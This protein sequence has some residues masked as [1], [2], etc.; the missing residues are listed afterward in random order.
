MLRR[1][2]DEA[3]TYADPRGTLTLAARRLSII[4]VEHGHQPCSNEDGTVWAVQNGEIYNFERL[5]ERLQAEG[6]RLSSRCDTEVLVHLYERYGRELVHAIE[7][8]FAFAIW[9]EPRQRLLLGRDRC[10]EKPLFVRAEHGGIAFASELHALMEAGAAEHIEL[11]PRSLDAYFVLGYVPPDAALVEGVFQLA[12]GS[13]L[14]WSP[15]EPPVVSSYWSPPAALGPPDSRKL[16]ELV[17]ET[18]E[19]LAD[20]VASRMVSDVPLGLFLSGGMD[21]TL[22]AAIARERGGVRTFSVGYDVGDV[23]ETP[24]AGAVAQRLGLQHEAVVLR[25][26]DVEQ[27][28]LGVLAAIDQ[29]L[30][31]QALLPTFELARHA[32]RAVKVIVGGEGADEFFA[33]YPRYRWL[34]RA[35]RFRMPAARRALGL[36]AHAWPGRPAR[37]ERLALLAADLPE[38]ARNVRWVSAGRLDVRHRLYGERL[39]GV[40]DRTPVPARSA[41]GEPNG[42]PGHRAMRRDQR[43]WLA[44]DVL[45]KADRAGM[46]NSLEIRTPYLNRE[47]IEFA[48]SVSFETHAHDGGKALL[49]RVLKRRMPGHDAPRKRGFAVPAAEWLRGPLRNYVEHCANDSRLVRDGWFDAGALEAIAREHLSGAADN[50]ATLWPLVALAAWLEGPHGARVG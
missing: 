48:C 10:G 47:L 23:S 9:D 16:D 13:I 1:G 50:A 43:T 46:L 31:D 7:G 21:S 41:A 27:L 24:A 20:A 34:E 15:G 32:R 33:G 12:P 40:L 14:E 22:V 17:A 25:S 39:R 11:D 26:D 35:A 4:D 6:H 2:P 30:A 42:S 28:A 19:L 36:A 18:D 44:G 38:D 29:P 37:R 49:R 3:G 8:M 5:R 45:S